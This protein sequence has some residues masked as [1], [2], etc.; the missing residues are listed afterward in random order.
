MCSDLVPS[1]FPQPE[2]SAYNCHVEDGGTAI[3]KPHFTALV[4][5]ALEVADRYL[6][7]TVDVAETTSERWSCQSDLCAV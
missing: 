3:S 4:I 2:S 1:Q 7:A 5:N 6:S